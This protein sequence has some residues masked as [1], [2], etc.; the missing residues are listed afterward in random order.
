VRRDVPALDPN[1]VQIA[2]AASQIVLGM[3]DPQV[4]DDQ[5][6]ARSHI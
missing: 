6:I 3:V 2:V 5:S 1:E 4:M